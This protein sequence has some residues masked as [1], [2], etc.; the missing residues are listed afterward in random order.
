MSDQNR[1]CPT[2]TWRGGGGTH[3]E[4]DT[5]VLPQGVDVL[6]GQLQGHS[7]GVEVGAVLPSGGREGEDV[8]EPC[9]QEPQTPQR[10]GGAGTHQGA[11]LPLPPC[12]AGA[13]EGREGPPP[14]GSRSNTAGGTAAWAPGLCLP[15]ARSLTLGTMPFTSR[16]GLSGRRQE[17]LML[18]NCF[19][20]SSPSRRMACQRQRGDGMQRRA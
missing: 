4:D 6:E 17:P 13:L 1:Q 8:R 9:C 10:A 7:V 2:P 20:S 15:L 3:L 18:K 14:S 16:L 19:T 12:W 11:F 5:D